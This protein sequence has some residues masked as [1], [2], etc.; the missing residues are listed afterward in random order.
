MAVRIRLKRMGKKHQPFYRIV[1]VDQRKKRDG[2]VIEEIGTYDPTR[3]PSH[4]QVKGERAQYWLSVGAQPS[5][6]V[7]KILKLTGDW[8]AHKGVKN[9]VSRVKVA[10]SDA[11]AAAKA[12]QAVEDEAIKR[13][14]DAAAEKAKEEAAKAA[15]AEAPAEETTETEEA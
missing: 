2:R 14:A 1:V 3:Q 4:M 6:Q 9:P 12:I 11:E 8:A 13:K 10:E 5:D 15:E 7:L